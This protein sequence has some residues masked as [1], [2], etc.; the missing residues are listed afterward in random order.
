[1]S[2]AMNRRTAS[3][4]HGLWMTEK[5]ITGDTLRLDMFLQWE[6]RFS[7]ECWGKGHARKMGVGMKK[8]SQSWEWV[9]MTPHVGSGRG[10]SPSVSVSWLPT[11]GQ[12]PSPTYSSCCLFLPFQPFTR[13]PVSVL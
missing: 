9:G 1:M 4:Q 3:A 7:R 5:W 8:E 11:R 13:K 2:E 10:V 12:M 6:G